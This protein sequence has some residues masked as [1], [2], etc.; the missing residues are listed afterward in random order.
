MEWTRGKIVVLKCVLKKNQQI[1]VV[2]TQTH[3]YK[4]FN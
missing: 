2:Q 4:D 1:I 3:I